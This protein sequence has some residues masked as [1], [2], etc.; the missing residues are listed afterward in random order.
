MHTGHASVL[1]RIAAR[2]GW[3]GAGSPVPFL[4]LTMIAEW[5]GAAKGSAKRDVYDFVNAALKHDGLSLARLAAHSPDRTLFDLVE[6][7]R[8]DAAETMNTRGGHAT[9]GEPGNAQQGSEQGSEQGSGTQQGKRQGSAQQG[10]AQQD[11]QQGSENGKPSPARVS[12]MPRPKAT[13]Q[14]EKELAES[15]RAKNVGAQQAGLSSSEASGA[16]AKEDDKSRVAN[17][18]GNF[19]GVVALVSRLTKDTRNKVA[20]ILAHMSGGFDLEPTHD[21]D[22][23]E[24]ALRL[25]TSRAYEDAKREED[26]RPILTLS[27]D[28][29]GSCEVVAQQSTDI[30]YAASTAGSVG[31]D[32]WVFKH[33]NGFL[34]QEPK[35]VTN[36]TIANARRHIGSQWTLRNGERF[37]LNVGGSVDTA[38]LSP[39]TARRKRDIAARDRV[40]RAAGIKPFPA[41][42]PGLTRTL[43]KRAGKL[44]SLDKSHPSI[45]D[46]G[47][48]FLYESSHC[49]LTILSAGAE[50]NVVF[51]DDDSVTMLSAMMAHAAHDQKVVW[52]DYRTL[53]NH[54]HER[55]RSWY[56][57]RVDGEHDTRYS[58]YM[59]NA[60]EFGG[61]HG[62]WSSVVGEREPEARA[63]PSLVNVA[64]SPRFQ[65]DH[66][67]AP[68][69]L[70]ADLL[71]TIGDLPNGKNFYYIPNAQ[72]VG[73]L[74][75]ALSIV[76]RPDLLTRAVQTG[77]TVIRDMY[78][79]GALFNASG[80]RW[81]EYKVTMICYK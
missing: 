39:G 77:R 53:P 80:G 73:G 15:I 32:V 18:A 67:W 36:S 75:D 6:S 81:N 63:V 2:N 26:G 59:Q 3:T 61:N 65:G 35:D 24:L 68:T 48:T 58:N 37:D 66:E 47:S 28:V 13:K 23:T 79:T 38:G 50:W 43:A 46:A 52:V 51:T 45:E 33:S 7:F 5:K 17:N 72:G 78:E 70:V 49:A 19:G 64:L 55:R 54:W 22:Y 69:T 62:F 11:K 44:D 1:E 34:S 27:C 25:A 4:P 20:S 8:H 14:K 74:I 9:H 41:E 71:H 42:I 56:V 16:R 30:A 10:G 40:A 60:V 31:S 57:K 12:T 29:S 76:A 21:W